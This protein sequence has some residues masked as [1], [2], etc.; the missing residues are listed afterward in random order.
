MKC[1]FRL[2]GIQVCLIVLKTVVSVVMDYSAL[3]VSTERMYLKSKTPVVVVLACCTFS[4]THLLVSLL[5][6]RDQS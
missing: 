3:L 6:P 1:R 5:E 2:T 4:A